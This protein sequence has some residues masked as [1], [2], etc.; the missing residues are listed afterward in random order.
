MSARAN[1]RLVGV[2]VLVAAALLVVVIATL[3]GGDWFAAK[4]RYAVY[5]PGSVKGL[6]P[7][8]PVTFRGVKVGE[9]VDIVP[10]A[11]Q[12]SDNPVV[13]EVVLE[14]KATKEQQVR[15]ADAASALALAAESPIVADQHHRGDVVAPHPDASAPLP[16]G[17]PAKR[18][19]P[20]AL[21]G[22]TYRKET[23]LGT[24]FVT[25]NINGGDY[26]FEV[27]LNVGKAGSDVASVSEA[28]GRLISLVLRLPSPLNP[29]ERLKQV[30]DQLAGIGGGRTL[31][32][33]ANRVR[34]LPDAVA[35][36][37][38]EH[39]NSHYET[40]EEEAS[41]HEVPTEQLPLPIN[42]RPVGDL[43]P[44]C[45]QATFIPTEGCRKCYAC[46]YSEC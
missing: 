29:N 42:D 32:F 28:V 21:W 6:N 13:I 40:V 2:F 31:G 35:Q 20:S 14:T 4:D 46:G 7:G 16:P 9:V 23:P 22:M 5:F 44:D 19:R 12:N 27:F 41:A 34:S 30:I 17:H 45:G 3:T 11:T 43:C 25:V 36:V 8:A 1:P 39:L 18:P 10:Y 24:A 26:P 38:R 33:G 15:M 37:L